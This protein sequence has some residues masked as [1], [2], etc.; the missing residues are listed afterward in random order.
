MLKLLQ[1]QTHAKHGLPV[2]DSLVAVKRL[3]LRPSV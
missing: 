3:M 1:V 2:Y